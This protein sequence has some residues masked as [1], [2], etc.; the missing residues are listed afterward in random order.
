MACPYCGQRMCSCASERAPARAPSSLVDP[1]QFDCSE[2]RFAASLEENAAGESPLQE[3]RN[4]I[5]DEPWNL[6]SAV[7]SP[8]A[9]AAAGQALE[10]FYRMDDAAF[11]REEVASRV[12]NYRA[13]RRRPPRERSLP[14]DFERAVHRQEAAMAAALEAN[15]PVVTEV[16]PDDP[17]ADGPQSNIIVFPA[18]PPPLEEL[19]AEPVLDRP[20]ILD[21]PEEVATAQAPLADISLEPEAQDDPVALE[22][23][24]QVATM[25]QRVFA[26]LLDLLIVMVGAAVFV[27]ILLKFGVPM[28]QARAGFLMAMAAPCFFW[29]VY[30]YMFLVYAG[31][32]P[33]MQMGRLALITFDGYYVSRPRRRARAIAMVLSSLSLG[34]GLIWALLDEDT[35]CWHDRI[36]QTYIVPAE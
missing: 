31:L 8:P 12:E 23:P 6:V 30:E 35:L 26:G 17:S 21:V 13:R 28:P 14:L 1:D 2:E 7:G 4:G 36:T 24:L 22:L 11:W 25:S 15:E 16:A 29:A 27:M 33:G 5:E 19:V 34:L 10:P 3:A 18:P 9:A 20:R 32:T